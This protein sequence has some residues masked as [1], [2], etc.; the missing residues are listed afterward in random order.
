MSDLSNYLENALMNHLRN[1]AAFTMPA[2]LYLA[3]F[4]AFTDLEA[5]VTEQLE[6]AATHA[7]SMPFMGAALLA[8]LALVPIGLLIRSHGHE[9]PDRNR[10]KENPTPVQPPPPYPP[11]SGA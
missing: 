7:F 1:S 2:T 3:L 9:G 6:R 4:T 5:G 8:A 10:P 11:R